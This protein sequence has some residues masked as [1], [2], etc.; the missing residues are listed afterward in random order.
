MSKPDDDVLLDIANDQA[1][2]PLVAQALQ[3]KHI[4]WNEQ[5]AHREA[6]MH[7]RAKVIRDR[8][9]GEY[10]VMTSRGLQSVTRKSIALLAEEIARGKVEVSPESRAN[11]W[12]GL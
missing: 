12:R 4:G 1:V 5:D 3:T 2:T 10:R 8:F 6:D 9:T 11:M 7:L